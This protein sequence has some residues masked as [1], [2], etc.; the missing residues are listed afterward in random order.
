MKCRLDRIGQ[1][2]FNL[3]LHHKSIHDNFYI[4][5]FIFFKFRMLIQFGNIP[6]YANPDKS[7]FLNLF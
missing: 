5:F 1:T 6:V 2:I 3:R 7:F 4:M